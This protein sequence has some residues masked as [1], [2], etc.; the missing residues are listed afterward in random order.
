[1]LDAGVHVGQEDL[2]P[3]SVRAIVGPERSVGLSTHN[4]V[5]FLQGTAAPVDYLAVG[6]IFGT[7]NKI[8]PDPVV[9][10]TELS[11]LRG[12]TTKPVVAIGGITRANA[13]DVWNTGADSV[14]VIGDMYPDSCSKISIRDRFREW[15][16]I[17]ANE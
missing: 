16:M 1:M 13:R 2:P 15:V 8:D 3:A 4:Q 11:R 17:A 14:A 10:T 7:T 6:P 12:M 5:Q 9:G